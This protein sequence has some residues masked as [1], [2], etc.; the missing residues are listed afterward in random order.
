MTLYLKYRPQRISEL[1]LKEVRE[2][3]SAFIKAGNLPHAFLFAGPKGTGK[4][5]AAR[6]L[7]KAVNCEKNTEKPAEPCNQCEQCLSITAGNNLDVIEIDAASHRGIDDIRVLKDSI[8]LAPT[9]AKK[10]VYIIDEAHML[11]VEASNAL[12]KTLEEPPAHVIFILATTDPE[13]LIPTIRSRTVLVP[14]RKAKKEELINS[15]LVKVKGEKKEFEKEA[16]AE[17]ASFADGSFRDA[18]KILEQLIGEGIPLKAK[19][20]SEYLNKFGDFDPDCFLGDLAA[21]KLTEALREMR[22][23]SESG[24]EAL[25]FADKILA[26]LHHNLFVEVGLE[27]GEAVLEKGKTISLIEALLEA[28]KRIAGSENDFLPLEVAIVKWC[29][30]FSALS[31]KGDKGQN[32]LKFGEK[33]KKEFPVRPKESVSDK[34]EEDNQQL[35][36]LQFSDGDSLQGL[37]WKDFLAAVGAINTSVEA[38]LRAAKPLS[39]DGKSLNLGVYYQFHKEKLEEAKQKQILEGVLAKFFNQPVK[40]TCSLTKPNLKPQS[41]KKEVILTESDDQNLVEVAKSVFGS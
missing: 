4:T 24:A 11:T 15:L 9:R 40:V 21:G 39:F 25:D 8:K 14:F 18:A 16:L 32:N 2:S 30:D 7:A 23:V 27:E 20:V 12:L 41:R 26:S 10:K 38:L 35:S 34:G 28:K 19:E 33:V 1:D 22:R 3:L 37:V 29:G 31:R 17:I 36:N 5:S 13:K 6:I